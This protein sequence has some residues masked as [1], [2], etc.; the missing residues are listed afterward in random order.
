VV[1]RLKQLRW[2]VV[3]FNGGMTAT[4]KVTYANRRVETWGLMRDAIRAGMELPDDPELITD[5]T[6]PEYGFTPKQQMLLE[7]KEDMK[8]RGLASPDVAD[9]LSMTFAV[10]P[11]AK[12]REQKKPRE[13]F[14]EHGAAALWMA[15]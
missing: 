2:K 15:A 10:N 12:G 6:G 4:D 13:E 5:L 14:D 1:D 11:R 9:M 8:K 7:R 3:P